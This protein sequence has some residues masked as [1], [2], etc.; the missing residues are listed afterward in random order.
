MLPRAPQSGQHSPEASKITGGGRLKKITGEIRWSRSLAAP[1]QDQFPMAGCSPASR[2][3][4]ALTRRADYKDIRLPPDMR[5]QN[6]AKTW[7]KFCT[8]LGEHVPGA[9][10][11]HWQ[12]FEG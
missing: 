3:Q 7:T 2:E 5:G 10:A 1:R 4:P 11:G 6:E 9:F 12:C 8:R